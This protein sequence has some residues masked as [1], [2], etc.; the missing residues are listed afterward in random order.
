[1]MNRPPSASQENGRAPPSPFAGLGPLLLGIGAFSVVVNLLTLTGAI[2]MLQVY[3]RVLPSRSV[4]TLVALTGLVL[5]LFVVQG[6]LDAARGRLLVRLAASLEARL[7]PMLF[8][9]GL[10]RAAALN[11]PLEFNIALRDLDQVRAFLGSAGPTVFFDAPFVP[12]FVGLCLLLHPWL[13]VTALVGAIVIIGLSLIGEVGARGRVRA[14]TERA[15]NRAFFL[16]AARRGAEAGRALGMVETLTRR[17]SALDGENRLGQERLATASANLGA[18]SRTFRVALQSLLL[19]IGAYLVIEGA[20]TGGVMIAASI[21][22][23]RALAPVEMAAAHYK[24]FL[25]TGQAWGR[26]RPRLTELRRRAR[27]PRTQLPPPSARIEVEGLS[28]MPPGAGRP[29]LQA[30]TF[31]LSAGE[32]LA[33]LGP[34]GAGKTSLLRVLAGLWPAAVGSVRLDGAKH[35]QWDEDRL[36]RALGYLPQ[37]PTL[38]DGTVAEN[39]ARFDP[40]PDAAA[41]IVAAEAAGVH[42]LVLGLPSGYDTRIGEGG[43]VLAA[44]HRQRIALARALYGAP[45]LILLDE[46][47][48]HLD[49]VG[50]AALV[51]AVE[52]ARA[53]GAIV[54]MA[55]HRPSILRAASHVALL[56]DGR[57][58]AFGPRDEVITRRHRPEEAPSGASLVTLT[59][60]RP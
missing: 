52:E 43:L 15:Q 30:I 37:D 16:E 27:A 45:F 1:M 33:L 25:A 13:G 26:L 19:G 39:I 3:D 46:P 7:A 60:G 24:G 44:G 14:A 40:A 8:A 38:M 50:E 18:L 20:A 4:P 6:V 57:L 22:M 53:R 48:A 54:I 41:V 42:G 36:G 55:A 23:G 47:N 51:K 17:F 56:Q 2:Y 28:V 21:L 11:T 12:L 34:S 29:L 32:G 31:T 9:D 10:R 35:D 49:A 59:G 5:G 58:G